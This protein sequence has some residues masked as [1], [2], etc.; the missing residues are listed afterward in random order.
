MGIY[1]QRKPCGRTNDLYTEG[2]QR[3]EKNQRLPPEP[4]QAIADLNAKLFWRRSTLLLEVSLDKGERHNR[5]SVCDGINEK[6][7]ELLY[8]IEEAAKKRP[9]QE[10]H[11][12]GH[13]SLHGGCR[14]LFFLD[15]IGQ[16]GDLSD[17]KEHIEGAFYER[18]N[19]Q[20]YQRRTPEKKGHGDAG[21]RDHPPGIAEK[22][23]AFAI[24]AIKKCTRREAQERIRQAAYSAHQTGLQRG[25][26]QE[27]HQQWECE[28][29]HL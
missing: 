18:D 22:H 26:G 27:Q 21:K 24:P 16:R 20:L 4:E 7:Q 29:R 5:A 13:Y 15:D 28:K 1:D 23:H 6:W 8:A 19:I 14:K 9:Q 11:A 2:Q 3:Q 17:V 12:E 10:G 25:V